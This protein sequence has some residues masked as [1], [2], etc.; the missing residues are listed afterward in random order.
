MLTRVITERDYTI[1]YSGGRLADVTF[2]G[3][4]YATECV[5]VR[6][7]DFA[8]GCFTESEP[9]DDAIR[10]A[11]AEHIADAGGIEVYR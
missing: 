7:Y 6:A 4:R 10:K 3:A 2:R 5:Q 1:T 9:S 8:K 11:V